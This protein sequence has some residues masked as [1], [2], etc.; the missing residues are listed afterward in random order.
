MNG[1]TARTAVANDSIA[2]AAASFPIG[3]GFAK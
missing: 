1:G 2:S 3:D